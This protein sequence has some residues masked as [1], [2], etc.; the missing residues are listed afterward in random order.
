M[1]KIGNNIVY[2]ISYIGILEYYLKLILIILYI[3]I[4]INI[5]G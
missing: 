3:I 2:E 4:T 5:F 1:G